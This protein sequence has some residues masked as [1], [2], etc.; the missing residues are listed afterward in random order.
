MRKKDLLKA[1]GR[2]NEK[3]MIEAQ[4]YTA[5]TEDPKEEENT[6][7]GVDVMSQ[8]NI[9]KKAAP[10]AAIAAAFVLVVGTAVYMGK[11]DKF[12]EDVSPGSQLS[13]A[14]SSNSAASSSQNMTEPDSESVSDEPVEVGDGIYRISSAPPREKVTLSCEYGTA[15]RS[16]GAKVQAYG[17]TLDFSSIPDEYNNDLLPYC[18]Y[19]EGATVYFSDYTD[20]YK[21]DLTLIAPELLFTLGDEQNTMPDIVTELIA[22]SNTELLF[23]RGYTEEGKC[24]GSIDPETGEADFIIC[25]YSMKSVPCNNG[26]MLYDYLQNDTALYWECGTF[27]E[28][29]LCN[30]DEGERNAWVSASGKYFCTYL[31]GKAEDDSLVER[32]SVYDTK[33]GKF[34]KSFDW[35]FNKKVAE[36]L[37]DG[38]LF[39]QINEETQS[40]YV[41]NTEDGEYYQFYFGG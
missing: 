31:W 10:P 1:L 26:V 5:K 17:Q 2:I 11:G 34:L 20:F 21:S 41:K 16:E 6:V 23:F 7:M 24:I 12:N 37:P 39:A 15:K 32:W 38:F 14:E 9:W 40:V 30:P 3:Y 33:S 8:K 4:E 36:H 22:F 19:D 29:P 18:V 25:P 13:A 35:T 28:I 27:Y